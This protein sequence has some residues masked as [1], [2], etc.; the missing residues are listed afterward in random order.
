MPLLP[1]SR[2]RGSLP[3]YPSVQ[4]LPK[5]EHDH[6]PHQSHQPSE[7]GGSRATGSSGRFI[8]N[9][10]LLYPATQRVSCGNATAKSAAGVPSAGDSADDRLVPYSDCS[11]AAPS[12]D[13]AP[14]QSRIP[15]SG[16]CQFAEPAPTAFGSNSGRQPEPLELAVGRHLGLPSLSAKGGCHCPIVK[17][18]LRRDQVRLAES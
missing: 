11:A 1:R 4:E 5:L 3:P 7:S 18:C 6:Q 12:E 15:G 9:A 13:L 17:C 8:P 10:E 14:P 16:P 2:L